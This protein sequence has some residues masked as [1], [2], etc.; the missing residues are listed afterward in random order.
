MR[1]K[2]TQ[3]VPDN[4]LLMRSREVGLVAR[5]NSSGMNASSERWTLVEGQKL[6]LIEST[7][8]LQSSRKLESNNRKLAETMLTEE[9][10][11]DSGA[12]RSTLAI[13]PK[14]EQC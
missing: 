14:D 9:E 8:I 6:G 2:P 3:S 11:A 4:D 13:K 12:L 1:T 5:R 10:I 7:K